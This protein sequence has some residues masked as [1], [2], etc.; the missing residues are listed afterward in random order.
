MYE[1]LVDVIVL[2]V[3]NM[4]YGSKKSAINPSILRPSMT[5]LD[6]SELPADSPLTIEARERGCKVVEPA[7]VF[8]D[9]I[10]TLFKSLTGQELPADAFAA[11][12]E[13]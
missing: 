6:L 8:A 1:T 5:I 4:D 13:E 10:G 9:Y 12:L 3:P 11:G 2:T 7:E